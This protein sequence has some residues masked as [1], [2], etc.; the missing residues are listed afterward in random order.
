MLGSNPRAPTN[1]GNNTRVKIQD[2]WYDQLPMMV[3]LTQADKDN[4]TNMHPDATKYAI[5]DDNSSKEDKLAWMN[6]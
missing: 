2:I 3:E 5:F 1:L 6:E 4:I